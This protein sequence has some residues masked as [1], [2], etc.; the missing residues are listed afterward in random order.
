[1]VSLITQNNYDRP[2]IGSTQTISGLLDNDFDVFTVSTAIWINFSRFM[3]RVWSP[4]QY[5]EVTAQDAEF[6]GHSIEAMSSMKRS[7]TMIRACA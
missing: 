2:P 5:H 3:S 4:R 7:T 6:F 1:M